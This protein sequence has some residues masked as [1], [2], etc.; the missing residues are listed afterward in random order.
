MRIFLIIL[1]T[2]VTLL[3]QTVKV[4]VG[5]TGYDLADYKNQ[6]ESAVNSLQYTAGIYIPVQK[7]LPSN[8]IFGGSLAFTTKNN[9]EGGFTFAAGKTNSYA[10][11]GDILGN[12]DIK[13]EYDMYLMGG[14]FQSI[15]MN[16]DKYRIGVGGSASLGSFTY[17]VSDAV[18]YPQFPQYNS[19]S[20]D[21]Y[22]G[23]LFCIEPYFT[24]DYVLTPKFFITSRVGFRIGIPV[25]FDGSDKKTAADVNPGG[26]VI[27]TGL[28]YKF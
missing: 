13:A 23:L 5:F 2:Q 18:S 14:Y 22:T 15:F 6:F 19:S 21:S 27:S 7:N 26:Y 4:F 25:N 28:G 1:F 10:L 20:S 9:L 8:F 24:F 17:S 11:Y 12:I 3:A 16:T